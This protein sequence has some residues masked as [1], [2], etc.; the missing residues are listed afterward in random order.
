MDEVAGW[1]I[2]SGKKYRF[3]KVVASALGDSQIVLCR[4]DVG[5]LRFASMEEWRRF[6][7]TQIADGA[8][9]TREAPE[10][11]PVTRDSPWEQ[12]ISLIMSLFRGRS[13]VYAEGY[14]GKSTKEGKLS[15]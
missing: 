3:D 10:T 8:R 1:A 4:D 11:V 12:K 7:D 2:M 5:E 9:A 6:S 15:Y 13:D 14:V